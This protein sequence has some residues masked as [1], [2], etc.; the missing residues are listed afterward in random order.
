MNTICGNI[1]SGGAGFCS[2]QIPRENTALRLEE[3]AAQIAAIPCKITLEQWR[4]L[5]TISSPTKRAAA[6][7]GIPPQQLKALDDIEAACTSEIERLR[8][9]YSKSSVF[10]V[11]TKYRK[12]LE[13]QGFSNHPVMSFFKLSRAEYGNR[14]GAYKRKVAR[15]MSELRPLFDW[16]GYI[17]RAT[18][19][20]KS[21]SYINVTMGL[22]ALTGRRPGEILATARFEKT[23]EFTAKFTGQLKTKGSDNA[24]DGYEV[25]LLTSADTVIEALARLRTMKSFNASKV[26]PG[27]TQGQMINRLTANSQAKSV[28]RYFL[29]FASDYER[30]NGKPE[31]L[32][33]LNLRSIYALLAWEMWGDVWLKS[34]DSIDADETAFFAAMLGHSEGDTATAQSYRNFTA[35]YIGMKN[36]FSTTYVVLADDLKELDGLE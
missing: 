9:A 15:E 17:N 29:E 34:I 14:R 28:R 19:L 36:P 33:P 12:H 23:G 13:A 20:L 8:D 22:C 21:D 32:R 24:R 10:S 4:E 7:A 26:K 11:V 2:R 16:E 31:N 27:E 3:F 18:W 5:N 1:N 30:A 6:L 35:R 25:Y